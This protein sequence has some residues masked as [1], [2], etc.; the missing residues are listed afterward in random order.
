M[1]VSHFNTYLVGGAA[2]AAQRL[3][4]SL[5]NRGVESKFF[6]LAGDTPNNSYISI[7]QMEYQSIT[8]RMYRYARKLCYLLRIHYHTHGRPEG[9]EQFSYASLCWKT[10]LAMFD[11]NPDLIHLHWIADF[12]DYPSFFS[13]IPDSVPI[14]WT[15]HDMNPFTGGCHYSWECEGYKS[16]CRHCPQLKKSSHYDLSTKNFFLKKKSLRGKNLH[17]VADSH[18]LE[19]EARSSAIFSN[20]KSFQTIHYGL[21]IQSFLPKDKESCRRVLGLPPDSFVISFGADHV[22]NKRKGMR[23]LV[24]ALSSIGANEKLAL[25]VFGRSLPQIGPMD[26]PSIH[27]GFLHSPT[28]L[29][30]IYSASDM[31]VIPSLQEAFGQTALESLACG[32]PVVGFRTGGIPDMV[33]HGKTGLLAQPND[34]KELALQIK[35]LMDHPEEKKQMGVNGR[36]SVE[37]MFTADMQADKY[38]SLYDKLLNR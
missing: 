15:L 23:E 14:I 37:Q 30:A 12:I 32:T 19:R 21:D 4:D 6:S 2:I 26:F 24:G 20:V 16:Q 36:L 27:F 25:L 5:T 3:H 11:K 17:I 10:R 9:Y 22:G 1:R 35:W 38:L 18:W 7:D 8:K 28:L 29:S 33:I 34:I 13:S 31:F